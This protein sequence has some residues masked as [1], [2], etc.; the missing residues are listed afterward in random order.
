MTTLKS[1]VFGRDVI[2][3][4]VDETW[5]AHYSGPEGKRRPTTSIMIPASIKE[6]GGRQYLAD[7]CHEWATGSHPCVRQL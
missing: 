4:R 2:V 7:L 1:D 6:A 3:S 5:K